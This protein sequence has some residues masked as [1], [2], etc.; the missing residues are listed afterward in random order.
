M[1]SE[2][3][4]FGRRGL[5]SDPM[6]RRED[7]EHRGSLRNLPT[8]WKKADELCNGNGDNLRSLDGNGTVV[9]QRRC[10]PEK[11][12]RGDILFGDRIEGWLM[13]DGP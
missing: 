2:E 4:P 10:N 9:R 11:D 7:D 1:G 3:A 8:S 6:A 12:D 5:R 13:D